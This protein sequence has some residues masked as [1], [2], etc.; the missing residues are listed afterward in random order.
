MELWVKR[1]ASPS[2]EQVN[3]GWMGCLGQD[4]PRVSRDWLCMQQELGTPRDGLHLPD[5]ASC[6]CAV[7]RDPEGRARAMQELVGFW[8]GMVSC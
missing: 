3:L 8:L 1:N 2:W 4:K 7:L 5:F 6:T